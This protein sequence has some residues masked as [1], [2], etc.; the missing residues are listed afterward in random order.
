V[1]VLAVLALAALLDTIHAHDNRIIV[2]VDH[3]RV[4]RVRVLALLVATMAILAQVIAAHLKSIR[5]FLLLT[6]SLPD[7]GYSG[8]RSRRIV[9]HA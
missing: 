6:L 7:C 3:A 5:S 2:R 4:P 1:K 9:R 8:R